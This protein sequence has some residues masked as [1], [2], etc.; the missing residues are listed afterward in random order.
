MPFPN[1]APPASDSLPVLTASQTGQPQAMVFVDLETTGSNATM[2]RIT[3]IGI[4]EVSAEGSSEWSSLVNPHARIPPFIERLTGIS[5]AMVAGAPAFEDL[6]ATVL[7]RLQGRLFVAHNARFDYG[8]LKNEFKRIGIDFRASVLCTVRL[9]RKL[10]P[11]FSRHNL[12]SLIER[13]RLQVDDRHRALGDARL[14]RQFW[15][16]VQN[17]HGAQELELA[18]AGLTGRPSLPPHLD[19]VALDDLPEGHGVYLFYGENELPLYIGKSKTLRR[20]VLSHF[21]AD[22]RIAKEMSLS[23]QVRR[24]D[25]VETQGELGS[26]LKESALVKQL[27]PTHNQRLRRARELCS[28]QLQAQSHGDSLRPVLRWASDLDLGR[29]DNLYGLFT[30]QREAKK[31]LTALATQHQL[32]LGLLGLESSTP[33]KP[34]FAHQLGRCSGACVG[35]QAPA[36]HNARLLIVLQS[37]KIAAWPYPCPVGIREGSD[38]HVVDA[39]CHLGTARHEAD[40]WDLLENGL[41]AFDK[42]AYNVLRN[43]LPR[44]PLVMLGPR[45]A[46]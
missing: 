43:W 17:S 1:T 45:R 16:S 10:Y 19:A 40:A 36:L 14:I 5:N 2:D 39:W 28:W 26:L 9:S 27:Q 4:V 44:S 35:K 32:C 31:Q 3:E 33:G 6:A 38:L 41:P 25:W 37:L 18:V 42:D 15:Q 23:Q 24:V 11:E 22:H 21:S 7:Q 34:C 12:D 8:F 46:S 30:S 20:R 13:H 29:Q